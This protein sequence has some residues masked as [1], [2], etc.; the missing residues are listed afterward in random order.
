MNR[1]WTILL[2]GIAV[3]ACQ[4][5]MNQDKAAKQAWTK[6]IFELDKVE[7]IRGRNLDDLDKGGTVA[8]NQFM[9]DCLAVENAGPTMEQLVELNRYMTEKQKRE[10]SDMSLNNG[11][12]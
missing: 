8:R 4:G 3:S 10:P 2:A 9:M 12:R 11:K 5:P 7:A 6:C 1:N